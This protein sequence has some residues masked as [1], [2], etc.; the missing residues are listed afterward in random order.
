MRRP[1]A[2]AWWI[3]WSYYARNRPRP[4]PEVFAALDR[5]AKIN[6]RES[7]N[8]S[9]LETDRARTSRGL[10]TAAGTRDR[11]RRGTGAASGSRLRRRARRWLIGGGSRGAR[12]AE[13]R[14]ALAGMRIEP[15]GTASGRAGF[16]A[17]AGIDRTQRRNPNGIVHTRPAL[18]R[19]AA[20]E[21]S[22]LYSDCRTLAGARHWGQYGDLQ[23]AGRCA[24]Q[25]AARAG[26]GQVSALRQR[27]R[28]GPQ[29]WLP[30][31]KL[32]PL[33]LSFLSRGE[34]AQWSLFRGGGDTEYPQVSLRRR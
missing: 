24:A 6:A 32:G 14:L 1:A 28:D 29:H 25:V 9:E 20:V 19:A 16:A 26:A 18:R 21:E 33:L 2:R 3:R 15:G 12:P 5:V 4:R 34:A 30:E 27:R 31:Q 13:L 17:I 7:H 22:W 10:A 11:D 8:E 23:F